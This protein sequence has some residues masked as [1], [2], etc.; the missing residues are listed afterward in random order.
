MCQLSG[1]HQSLYDK[2]V[3]VDRKPLLWFVKGDKR[4]EPKTTFEGIQSDILMQILSE[5]MASLVQVTR[6]KSNTS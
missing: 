3:F 5:R 6:W 4:M 2:G 1:P